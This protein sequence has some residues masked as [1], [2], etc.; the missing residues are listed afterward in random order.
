M[1]RKYKQ[2]HIYSERPKGE[3]KFSEDLD[4][5]REINK[6]AICGHYRS[7]QNMNLS[8]LYESG[9]VDS[10]Y[11]GIEGIRNNYDRIMA[12]NR[13]DSDNSGRVDRVVQFA[14]NHFKKN[15]STIRVL[16]IGSGLGVFLGK[17]MQKTDWQCTALETDPRFAKHTCENLGIETVTSDYL[18]LQWNRQ[19]DIITLNKV[20]EHV[21]EPLKM[22]Q[23]CFL[24]L[25][26]GGFLYIELPDGESAACDK[27]EF[28]REEFF[29]EHYHIFSMASMELLS[30]RAGLQS[31]ELER[32]RE[33]S[34][35]YTL[36][37]FLVHAN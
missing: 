37:S 15:S 20:L 6:C 13:S 34:S 24:D 27:E 5:H 32:I 19:F 35:K 25:A 8:S 9:Y 23:K 17:V 3:T 4:Y 1:T 31:K 29:I 30:R 11:G 14:Q 10:T 18:K 7:I 12:L 33:P 28:E 26:P 2:V 36:R 22:L 21:E 16:D